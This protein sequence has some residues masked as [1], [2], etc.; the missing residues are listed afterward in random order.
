[1]QSSITAGDATTGLVQQAGND[2][3]LVLQSGAAGSKVNAVVYAADGTATL[4]KVPVNAMAQSCIWLNT[5]NGYGSTNTAIKRYTNA[6]LNQGSDITYADSATL[7]ATFTI[8]TNGV[9]SMMIMA[10]NA[11]NSGCGVSLNSNQLTTSIT[12]ITAA[13][14]VGYNVSV[15]AAN[16]FFST[17]L[18]LS[19][20]AVIRA[21]CDGAASSTPANEQFQITRVA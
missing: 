6:I 4:L 17:T 18:Y 7:G 3:T 13:N 15:N 9:Y 2:G 1:M 11:G 19:A 5:S 21:H 12:G 16:G 8:N 14:R 20:G 10:N